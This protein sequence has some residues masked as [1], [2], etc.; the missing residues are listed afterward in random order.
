MKHY[1]LLSVSVP[2]VHSD[3][4]ARWYEL[5]ER[6]TPLAKTIKGIV[7]LGEGVWLLPR[8]PGMTFA[9]ECMAVARVKHLT[10]TARFVSMDDEEG[11]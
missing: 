5:Q 8:G 9:S 11:S 1:I 4:R 3:D 2:E 10:S 6:L 7:Q